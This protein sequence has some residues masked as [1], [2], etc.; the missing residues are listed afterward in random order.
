M[1]SDTRQLSPPTMHVKRIAVFSDTICSTF[2]TFGVEMHIVEVKVNPDYLCFCL[3]PLV[4]V[5]MSTVQAFQDDLRFALGRDS[6]EVIAPLPDT[7]QVAV[8]LYMNVA[9][10]VFDVPEP[11]GVPSP[12]TVADDELYIKAEQLIIHSGNVSTSYLQRM[13]KIGYGRAARLLDLMEER[14]VIDPEER[15]HSSE[16]YFDDDSDTDR[17]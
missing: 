9:R 10:E 16:H 12:W 14:G 7:K 17:F 1:D 15:R 3:I 8:Y 11:E 5:R 6:V 4:P 13:L 2:K